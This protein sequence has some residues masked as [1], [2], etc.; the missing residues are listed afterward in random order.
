M[1]QIK[2]A[3][4]CCASLL[5]GSVFASSFTKSLGNVTGLYYEAAIGVANRTNIPGTS[6]VPSAPSRKN[7]NWGWTPGLLVAYQFSTTWSTQL[8]GLWVSPQ[9]Y[10]TDEKY[11]NIVAYAAENVS[12]VLS[13]QFN[14]FAKAGLAVNTVYKTGSAPRSGVINTGAG[15]APMFAIGITHSFNPNWYI[16]T[17][18]TYIAHSWNRMGDNPRTA[19]MQLPTFIVGYQF[20][21]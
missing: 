4:A 19:S 13:S 17:A 10:N 15:F 1:K 5:A 9:Q 7:A 16:A 12:I 6:H 11:A 3:F 20:Q 2:L 21:S 18:Y 8:G 14:I